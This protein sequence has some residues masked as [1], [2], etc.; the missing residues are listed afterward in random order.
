M[1]LEGVRWRVTAIGGKTVPADAEQREAHIVFSNEKGGV[2]GSTGCN[3]FSGAASRDGDRLTF[4]PLA[5]TRMMCPG[6]AAATEQAFLAAIQATTHYRIIGQALELSDKAGAVVLAFE[7]KSAEVSRT[8][9][10]PERTS[11]GTRSRP[12]S[13]RPQRPT[14]RIPAS[15]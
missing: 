3:R 8:S 9:T 13:G 10:P 1:K 15:G 5:V 14:V 11:P 12:S 4:K 7:A 6:D 2:A